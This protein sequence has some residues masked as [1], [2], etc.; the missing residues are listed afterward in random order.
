MYEQRGIYG[1]SVSINDRKGVYKNGLKFL[2]FYINIKEGE[3]V[4]ITRLE[5]EGIADE[6]YD[7][8]KYLFYKNATPLASNNYLDREYLNKFKDD[9]RNYLLGNGYVSST[10]EGPEIF[11]ESNGKKARVSY[12]IRKKWQCIVS[13][14]K[15]INI[16]EELSSLILKG[17]KNSIGRPLDIVNIEK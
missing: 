10:V 4:K 17:M 9:I 3:K 15:L 6:N 7:E 11:I 2:N 5:F 13:D 16:S 8:F 14:I 1:S 12:E